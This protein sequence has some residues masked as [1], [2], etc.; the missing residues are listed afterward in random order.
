M[1][2]DFYIIGVRLTLG[3]IQGRGYVEQHASNQI[4]LRDMLQVADLAG[5]WGV[6]CFVALNAIWFR[7]LISCLTLRSSVLSPLSIATSFRSTL[8]YINP[9]SM[10]VSRVYCP[11]MGKT[12][13]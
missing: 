5:E 4:L 9:G 10:R 7:V 3:S 8:L 2:D 12:E 13:A 6:F 1:G 11:D